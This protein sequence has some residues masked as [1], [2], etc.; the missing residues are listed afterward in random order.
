MWQAPL[1]PEGDVYRWQCSRIRLYRANG[2]LYIGASP[3]W[4]KAPQSN[5]SYDYHTYTLGSE[6]QIAQEIL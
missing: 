4:W 2:T 1:R 5:L 6:L 3:L